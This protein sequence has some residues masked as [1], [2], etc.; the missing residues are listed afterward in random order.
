VIAELLRVLQ[1]SQVDRHGGADGQA[2]DLVTLIEQIAAQRTAGTGQ[3]H[4]IDR[5][6]ERTTK[7]FH[8]LKRQRI[9]PGHALDHAQADP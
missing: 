6:A 4:V 1:R 3:Q 2:I 5:A 9:G 8:F 7:G